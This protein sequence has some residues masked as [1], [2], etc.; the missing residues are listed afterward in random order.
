M[1]DKQAE[2]D[3]IRLG[4]LDKVNTL[5]K[6]LLKVD[7]ILEVKFD[8]RNWGELGA[9]HQV[10]IIPKYYINP[11]LESTEY[12][13]ARKRQLEEIAK[14]CVQS[15]LYPTYDKIQDMG[16]HW[17]IVRNCDHTWAKQLKK[18]G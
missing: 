9:V 13:N 7:G 4:I 15:G 17:Y 10:I 8:L 11:D 12:F 6:R 3:A 5:E 16:E 18:G 1:H 2:K 14:V